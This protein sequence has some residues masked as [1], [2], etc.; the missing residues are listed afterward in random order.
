MHGLGNDFIILDNRKGQIKN[1]NKLAEKI[2]ERR[3]GIGADQ[4][5]VLRNSRKADFRMQIIN[6]DGSEVEMCGNGIRC[7]AKY[8]WDNNIGS[9][10]L[11]IETLAGIIYPE[12]S[13]SQIKV[14]MGEPLFDGNDI[15]IRIF[16]KVL[17]FLIMIFSIF[18]LIMIAS[19]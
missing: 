12:K 18:R 7:L 17:R 5:L 10:K 4:L 16:L 19:I 14:D 15:P 6:A 1:L 8:I 11:T 13:G 2:C 9:Q 3:F